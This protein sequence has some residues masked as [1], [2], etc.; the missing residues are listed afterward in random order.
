MLK[1]TK[2]VELT[3]MISYNLTDI[4]MQSMCVTENCHTHIERFKTISLNGLYKGV[5]C[6]LKNVLILTAR[7]GYFFKFCII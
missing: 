3:K 1:V 6:T 2:C 5:C 7:L 4:V